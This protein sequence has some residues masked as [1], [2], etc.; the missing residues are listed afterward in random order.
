MTHVYFAIVPCPQAEWEGEVYRQFVSNLFR[1]QKSPRFG[2]RYIWAND[3]NCADLIVI[4]EPVSF[5]TAEYADFLRQ[6]PSVQ[7]CPERVFTINYDDA[8]LAFIPGIYA[9]MPARR[10]EPLFTV[11][12]G[13]LVN[14]SNEFVRMATP[15]PGCEPKFLFTFRGA[16]SSPVR[17]RMSRDPILVSCRFQKSKFTVVDAWFNHS[18]EQKREYVDEILETKFVLCP[19]GQG[20]ASHRLFESMELGRVP[21]IIADDWVAPNGPD[22]SEFSIRI[23]ECKVSSIPSILADR[24]SQFSTMAWSARQAWEQYFAPE[25]RLLL[26][27]DRLI[28]L[29][30]ERASFPGDYRI[31]WNI[32]RFH[33]GNVGT[34]WSRVWKLLELRRK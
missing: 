33:R 2:E 22:W 10:F 25:V 1:S 13:Y 12:G 15:N 28:D 27:L 6:I 23:P 5:K 24:E 26:M 8:P 11:A 14:S 16:L 30:N 17:Q 9:A 34:L 18:D 31:R 29:R 20:S 32:Q 7:N 19:R 3:P 4:L 21:V